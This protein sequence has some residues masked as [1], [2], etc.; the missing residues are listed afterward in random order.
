M[1]NRMRVIKRS[2]SYEDVSFDKILNRIR[3]LCF[4]EE[5]KNGL[6]IDETILAQKVV[7]EIYDGVK[8]SE[9]DDLSA[10]NA[11]SLYSTHPDFKIL[12]G[13]ITVSNLHKNTLNNFSDKIELMYNHVSNGIKKPLIA[14][15][16]YK[17]VQE[18]KSIIDEAIDY[19]KDYDYDFFGLKTLEKTYLYK[20]DKKIIERP[21]DMLMRVSLSIHRDNL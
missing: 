8:T 10:Q 1:Y 6:N 9:L 21:Q 15:Y 12:A 11:M 5:F 19:S 18:N 14:D 3:S 4:S 20:I 16:L 17:L 2:G 13:R 7:Q